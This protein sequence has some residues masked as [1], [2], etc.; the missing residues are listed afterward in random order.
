TEPRGTS[1]L[2][3]FHVPA[4]PGLSNLPQSSLF[5]QMLPPIV[6]LSTPSAALTT[7]GAIP[8]GATPSAALPPPTP[9]NGLHAPVAPAPYLVPVAATADASLA[10]APRNPPGL[11][12]RDS[13][14][15]AINT[16]GPVTALS[17]LHD[18]GVG[19]QLAGYQSA[20]AIAL[21]GPLLATAFVLLL[22]DTL[23][24]LFLSGRLSGRGLSLSAAAIGVLVLVGLPGAMPEAS[25]QATAA[26]D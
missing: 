11:Y 25:A 6:D 2:L 4:S 13:R 9:P 7:S 17:P 10:P 22:L 3:L 26:E 18:S 5:V 16:V 15:P 1:L 12:G 20:P 14:V 19:S 24:V 23:A 8:A 21:K